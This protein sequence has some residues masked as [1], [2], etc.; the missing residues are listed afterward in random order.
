MTCASRT[1][2]RPAEPPLFFFDLTS[3][4][5]YLA[6]ERI[7]DVV[8]REV[9]WVPVLAGALLQATGRRSWALDERRA[10]GMREVEERA[11]RRGLPPVRWPERWPNTALAALRAA[12][13]AD[14]LGRGRDFA[15]AAFRLHFVDGLALD[16]DD[17]VALAA[18]RAALDPAAALRAAADPAVKK[19]LRRNGERA[20]ALGAVGVPTTVVRGTPFWGDDR[21]EE[22]AALLHNDGEE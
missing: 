12:V 20:L 7:E 13:H 4:Y 1:P 3:A 11:R 6:A 9:R 5:A 22:A 10:A 19:E 17:H 21:L 8:G 2:A 16:V 18:E 15:L 14:A